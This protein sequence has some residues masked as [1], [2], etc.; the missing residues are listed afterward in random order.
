MTKEQQRSKVNRVVEGAL[1]RLYDGL[2]NLVSDGDLTE[3]EVLEA[4]RYGWGVDFADGYE[5]WI[6]A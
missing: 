4:L 6:R 1:D 5:E 2:D 3:A